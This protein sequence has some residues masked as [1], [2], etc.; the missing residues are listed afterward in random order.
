MSALPTEKEELIPSIGK[1][2]LK[3][4]DE[5]DIEKALKIMKKVCSGDFEARIINI[6]ATGSLGELFNTINDL[7]DRC[8]AYL[9]E[10]QA[11]MEHV[12]NNEYYRKIIETNMEGSFLVASKT[13]N[14]A[15]LAMQEK[16]GQFKKITASFEDTVGDAVE[17]IIS[18]SFHFQPLSTKSVGK[19]F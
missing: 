15:L 19:L 7:V 14:R 11:C 4:S 1:P 12:N 2:V 3:N 5:L 18:S 16:S 10:S 9:R 8:D 17:T 6:T 13:I